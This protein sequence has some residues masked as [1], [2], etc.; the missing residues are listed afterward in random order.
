MV[1]KSLTATSQRRMPESGAT[2]ARLPKL[3]KTQRRIKDLQAKL[4]YLHK[5]G[6]TG[7]Q[8]LKVCGQ[9]AVLNE[10]LDRFAGAEAGGAH[11]SSWSSSMACSNS[12]PTWSFWWEGHV[13]V[14]HMFPLLKVANLG[15]RRRVEGWVFLD[16]KGQ[17][18][19][20]DPVVK[21]VP[22]RRKPVRVFR[23]SDLE[24]DPE[25]LFS[26]QEKAF[27]SDLE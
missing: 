8:P 4:K 22:V 13:Q 19:F 25:K 3:A 16:L 10:K 5:E 26:E 23:E 7:A 27:W 11:R 17:V 6:W 2:T 15:T 24:R 20:F 14:L 12:V 21:W 9:A 18:G 1:M